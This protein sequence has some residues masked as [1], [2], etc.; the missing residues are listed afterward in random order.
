[1]IITLPFTWV[2]FLHVFTEFLPQPHWV[3]HGSPGQTLISFTAADPSTE[4]PSVSVSPKSPCMVS[5][6]PFQL[7]LLPS[8]RLSLEQGELLTP[9]HP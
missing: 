9:A 4:K 6:A 8:P 5:A 2:F 1:M 3:A 7:L